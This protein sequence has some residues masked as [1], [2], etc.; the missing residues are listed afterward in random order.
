MAKFAIFIASI[1]RTY[2][3]KKL[4]NY[5]HKKCLSM[6]RIFEK[7]ANIIVVSSNGKYKL[8]NALTKEQREILSIFN[9][10]EKLVENISSKT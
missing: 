6:S 2:M 1:L 3:V 8:L 5:A 9:L 10:C 4:H 7:L